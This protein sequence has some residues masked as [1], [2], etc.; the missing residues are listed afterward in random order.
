V[1][2]ELVQAPPSKAAAV[3]QW[4]EVA[5]GWERLGRPFETACAGLRAG[6][7]LLAAGDREGAAARLRA[8]AEVAERLGAAPLL[9]EVRVLARNAHLPLGPD[10][11]ATD[12]ALE[13]LGLT[14]RETEVLR[15]VAAGR[16]NRQIGEQLFIS[17]KTVSVHVSSILIKLG[18]AGRG[19]AAATAHRLRLFDGA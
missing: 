4:A 6:E 10:D 12:G 5:A 7:R 13:R 16:T 11:A 2:A 1:T 19:E 17:A 8:T 18:V 15:L 9:E 14:D 3:E